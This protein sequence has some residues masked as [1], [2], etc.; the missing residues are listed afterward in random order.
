MLVSRHYF[1]CWH[2]ADLRYEAADVGLEAQTGR[3]PATVLRPL[4]T[5]SGHGRSLEQPGEATLHGVVLHAVALGERIRNVC[6]TPQSRHARP[7][8]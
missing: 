3:G 1:R 6:F 4:V 2:V 8:D 5:L 7:E